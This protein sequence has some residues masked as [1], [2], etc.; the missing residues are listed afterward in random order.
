MSQTFTNATFLLLSCVF[1]QTCPGV[2]VQQLHL[3]DDG[4]K[5]GQVKAFMVRVGL[6]I[7]LPV[8]QLHLQSFVHPLGNALLHGDK[9]ILR[10]PCGT[11][12]NFQ[13]DAC[14]RAG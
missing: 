11:T 7:S 13:S 2:V 14:S 10:R 6:L 9:H 5:A 3:C 1:V 4:G 12:V 8:L